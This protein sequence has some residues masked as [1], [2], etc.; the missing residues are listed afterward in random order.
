MARVIS[1]ELEIVGV[2]GMAVRHYPALLRLVA[3]GAVRPGR[4]VR[5]RIG[6][7]DAGGALGAMA[8]EG[9]EGITV[10]DRF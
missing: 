8:S 4:L 10:I 9:A 1:R 6:L 5:R 7:A 2:H 3:S